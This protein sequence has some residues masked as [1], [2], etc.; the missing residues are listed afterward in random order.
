MPRLSPAERAETWVAACMQPDEWAAWQDT[1]RRLNQA[2]QA[3]RPCSDC[4]LGFASE[5]RSIGRCNGQPH[6][7]HEEDTDMETQT[8]TAL[9]IELE[10]P[11]RRVS[12]AVT[13]PCG[14]CSHQ[15]V[16][17][18]ADEVAAFERT[19]VAVPKLGQGLGLTLSASIACEFFAPVKRPKVV[20]D[21]E[22]RPKREMTP[23]QREAARQRMLHARAIGVAR[24]AAEA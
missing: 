15:V 17:R 10:Q 12:I 9:P 14:G 22:P 1:N 24:K 13:A 16:C 5:M 19:Q 7:D 21:G 6:G 18:I 3:P 20:P 2:M 4:L 23:E 11:T 8:I